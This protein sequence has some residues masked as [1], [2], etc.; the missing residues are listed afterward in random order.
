MIM[1]GVDAILLAPFNFWA[2]GNPMV[3]KGLKD[4]FRLEFWRVYL[5]QSKWLS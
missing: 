2:I 1:T 4:N 3:E 5:L